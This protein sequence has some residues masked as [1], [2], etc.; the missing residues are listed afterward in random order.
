MEEN[1]KTSKVQTTEMKLLTEW[2][3][4]FFDFC[5]KQKNYS[6][7]AII[8]WQNGCI[9]DV[10]YVNLTLTCCR[11]FLFLPFCVSFAWS[12]FLYRVLFL[13]PSLFPFLSPFHVPFPA[14][15]FRVLFLFP[16]QFP[17]DAKFLFL[18]QLL[19]EIRCWLKS[20][21][22]NILKLNFSIPI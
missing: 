22:Y 17:F 6:L 21:L 4:F 8:T 5:M 9:I 15:V 14:P 19:R 16:S 13:F 7:I 10:Y 11:I 18:F 3:L 20:K 12:C 2:C 1:N